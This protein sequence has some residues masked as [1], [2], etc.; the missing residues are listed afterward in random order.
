MSKTNIALI[1]ALI[2]A[3]AQ[4]F[5]VKGKPAKKQGPFAKQRM[6]EAQAKRDRKNARRAKG[7]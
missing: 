1:G 3:I 5:P 2:A 4:P 6:A 7:R